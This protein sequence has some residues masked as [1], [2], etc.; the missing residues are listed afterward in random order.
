VL[1]S[2]E[3]GVRKPA[4]AFFTAVISAGGCPPE[5]ILFV[6]DDVENDYDGAASAG[7]VS[8]L[9]DPEYRHPTRR[10]IRTVIDLLD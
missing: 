4:T 10:R 3:I 9:L 5:N 1:I 8:L 7:L 2:S 6:G